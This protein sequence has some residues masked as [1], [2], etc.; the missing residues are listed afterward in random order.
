MDAIPVVF[1]LS[2]AFI[3]ILALF[4]EVAWV[5]VAVAAAVRRGRTLKAGLL[6]RKYNFEIYASERLTWNALKRSASRPVRD[7]SKQARDAEREAAREF[8]RIALENENIRKQTERLARENQRA[9]R[10]AQRAAEKAEREAARE[11]ERMARENENLKQEAE[12][13][14][15]EVEREAAKEAERMA[16]ENERAAREAERAAQETARAAQEAEREAQREA[17]LEAARIAREKELAERKSLLE[18]ER[19]QRERELAEQKAAFEAERTAREK[20]F[21]ERK[22]AF[23]AE[24]TARE[25]E[26]AEQKAAFEAE[27]LAR[28]QA[29]RETVARE[30]ERIAREKAAREAAAR[31]AERLAREE[32]AREAAAREAERLAHEE[33]TREAERLAHEEAVREAAQREAERLVREEAAREVAA[34][35]AER[36]AREQVSH[37]PANAP[38]E[39]LQMRRDVLVVYENSSPATVTRQVV[40]RLAPAQS[41]AQVSVTPVPQLAPAEPAPT[42]ASAEPA[43]RKSWFAWRSDRDSAKPKTAEQN[44]S[45]EMDPDHVR[46]VA[47]RL[48]DV[49]RLEDQDASPLMDQDTS[50]E[51]IQNSLIVFL[52]M[53]GGA[54]ATTLAVNTACSLLGPRRSVCLIDF[55]VQFGGVASL[56][57]LP[58]QPGLQALM[59]DPRRLERV[60]LESMLVR[61]KTGV[62]VLTAPRVPIPLHGLKPSA[63]SELVRLAKE[64]FTHVV[65]DM[66]LA[67]TTWTD[68]VLTPANLIYLVTPL[69]VQAAHR[70]AK[71]LNLMKQQ[72]LSELP[73]RIV[74]TRH[75]SGGNGGEIAPKQFAKAIGRDVDHIM[76]DDSELVL[77][78]H[79][80]G[81][82]VVTL[83]PK[84]KFSQAIAK[85]LANDFN[86]PTAHPA[87]QR[88]FA[89]FDRS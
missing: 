78:S 77:Q 52:H 68:A 50:N 1:F 3:A 63:V 25:K 76:P 24:R 18:K 34:R 37:A 7:P 27:R 67:L 30:A 11:V 28:E 58:P 4:T 47:D 33:A 57:D 72:D 41:A 85:M 16:R 8:K 61:H 62:H 70:A 83:A 40:T 74:A 81:V 51:H 87:S 36:I 46:N 88:K 84:A 5:Q 66:P 22:A 45:N 29:A 59:Q 44:P 79:N 56:M 54:G 19:L 23:E 35:E 21:A 13:V 73:V 38:V 39:Q 64:S 53:A 17:A 49:S 86:E 14:A 71:L 20:E 55:D 10:D 89:G 26:L 80:Q 32:A 15:R 75:S 65:V 43:T 69:T 42:S 2:I 48:A 12:R 60:P 31:E 82:P 9:K 6:R